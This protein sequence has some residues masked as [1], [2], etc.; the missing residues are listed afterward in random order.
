VNVAELQAAVA[1]QTWYHTI[2]LAPGVVTPGRYDLRSVIDQYGL[3]DDLRGRT[4]LDVG[5]GS[6]FFAFELERRSAARVVATELPDW[7]GIDK[8]AGPGRATDWTSAEWRT[9][10]DEPFALARAARRSRVELVRT[11]IY[12]L[13]PE[14]LGGMFDVV[15]CASVLVHV[16]DPV[17]ALA[18]LHS[19]TLD[20]A[21][22]AT[23]IDPDESPIPRAHFLGGPGQLAWWGPNRACLELLVRTAGFSHVEWVSTFELSSVDGVFRSPHAVLIARP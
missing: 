2:E 5:T 3:P 22:I 15:L 12:E 23:S 11:S 14:R 21:I 13:S 18:A 20:R 6:G 8:G 17:R 16:S 10:L 19:V 4:A 7:Q 1:A 9:Y